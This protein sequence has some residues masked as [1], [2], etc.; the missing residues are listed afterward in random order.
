MRLHILFVSHN[1]EEMTVRN[2]KRCETACNHALK[3]VDSLKEVTCSIWVTTQHEKEF[4]DAHLK[5]YKW[6]STS[7]VKDYIEW[8][9]LLMNRHLRTTKA[10]LFHITWDDHG[11]YEDCYTNAI[12]AMLLRFPKKT[13]H[14]H[15]YVGFSYNG[16]IGI[17][18]ANYPKHWPWQGWYSSQHLIGAGYIKG[19]E[20][21]HGDLSLFCPDYKRVMWECE[22]S[23]SIRFYNSIWCCREAKLDHWR[24]DFS[25]NKLQWIPDKSHTEGRADGSM[26]QDREIFQ[27]RRKMGYYWGLNFDLINKPRELPA[28]YTDSVEDGVIPKGEV[29]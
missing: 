16:I 10:D 23:A 7:I 26:K 2:I 8:A 13:V 29:Q 9:P 15:A 4:F 6:I 11:V 22:F 25:G 14:T 1:R 19:W 24:P 3:N 27:E 28:I 18:I 5:E 20:H 12:K 17:D 21:L